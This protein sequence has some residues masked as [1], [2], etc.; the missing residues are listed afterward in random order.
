MRT[1]S[2][3]SFLVAFGA[4]LLAVTTA[5]AAG[6]DGGKLECLVEPYLKVSVSSAV[7]GVLETVNV[8]RGSRVTK[9]EVLASLQSG[10]ERAAVDS[11]KAKAAFAERKVE[12]VREMSRKQ[13]ISVGE[14]DELETQWELLKLELREAEEKLKQRTILSPCDGVVVKRM[15]S[16]GEFVQEKP[17]LDLAQLNPLRIEVVVP[18]RYYG[19]IKS[20]MT[21]MVEWES[22]VGGTY[23]A[24]VKIVD[25]VV[26]AAS[27]T[28]GVRLE[29]P[30]PNLKLPAGTKCSVRF[31]GL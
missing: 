21:G 9:G 31:T 18:V 10:V 29:L 26:D 13:M 5:G 27:G 1:S 6:V 12:R 16:P 14:K 17:I 22:P 4:I 11:A 20:G 8:D 30:N 25:S 3:P 7:P 24:T 23:P 15:N 28:I 2:K 19:K